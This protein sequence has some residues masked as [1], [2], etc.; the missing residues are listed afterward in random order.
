MAVFFGGA[1]KPNTDTARDYQRRVA[2]N[3]RGVEREIG[4]LDQQEALLQRELAGCAKD[5]SRM[6]TASA[7][8]KEIVRLR[9]HRARLHTVKAHMTGLAQQLQ[10]VQATGKIQETIATTGKMLHA[11]NSRCD[12][13]AMGRMLAE[14]E[15]QNAQM[16]GKQELMDDALEAGFEADGEQEDCDEAIAGVLSEAGLDA[17]ARMHKAVPGLTADDAELAGRLERLRTS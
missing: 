7:K 17:Q 16:M 15:R 11:L 4:R 2:A 1:R 12:A 5:S 10:T 14:Y 6:E 9:A 3:A 13:A 8:A